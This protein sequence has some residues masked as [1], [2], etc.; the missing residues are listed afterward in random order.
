MSWSAAANAAMAN[1]KAASGAS[2]AQMGQLLSDMST[3]ANGHANGNHFIPFGKFRD[4]GVSFNVTNHEI[5]NV[6]YGDNL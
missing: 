4:H 3:W 6:A 2:D 5:R 1:V